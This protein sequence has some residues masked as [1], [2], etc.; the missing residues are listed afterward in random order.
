MAVVVQAVTSKTVVGQLRQAHLTLFN[1]SQGLA[2]QSGKW[3]DI[4]R[5][6]VPT[7]RG[8]AARAPYFHDGSANDLSGVVGFYNARFNIGLS[9]QEITDLTNFQKAL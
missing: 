4:R 2:M 8:L 3:Q 9:P 1:V 7:L 5:F 6:K